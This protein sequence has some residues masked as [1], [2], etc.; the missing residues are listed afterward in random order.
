LPLLQPLSSLASDSEA[1][2]TSPRA[3]RQAGS[4]SLEEGFHRADSSAS[5]EKID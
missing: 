5:W 1:I 2:A 3:V 4:A